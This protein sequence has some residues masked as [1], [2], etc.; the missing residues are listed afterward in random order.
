[1]RAAYGT[2]LSSLVMIKAHDMVADQAAAEFNVTWSR[3]TPIVVSVYD[4]AYSTILT[5]ECDHRFGM[6]VIGDPADVWAFRYACSSAINPIEHQVMETLFPGG[7]GRSITIGLAQMILNGEMVDVFISNG[8][9]V[10]MS[11]IEDLYLVLDLETGIVRDVMIT[12]MPM[13]GAY[14]FSDLQTEWASELCEDL[15]NNQSGLFDSIGDLSVYLG[16][17]VGTTVTATLEGLSLTGMSM[18]GIASAF[19]LGPFVFLEAMNPHM[20]EQ[21]EREGNF[22]TATWY[23]QNFLDRWKDALYFTIFQSGEWSNVLNEQNA[24]IDMINK[25]LYE[26][27]DKEWQEFYDSLGGIFDLYSY[28]DYKDDVNDSN[29]TDEEKQKALQIGL[30]FVLRLASGGSDDDNTKYI[31]LGTAIGTGVK[32]VSE[33]I[34]KGDVYQIVSG[35][36]LVLTGLTIAGASL[37]DGISEPLKV[38]IKVIT[39]DNN[40]ASGG[41]GGGVF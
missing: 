40:S 11:S 9:Q 19:I 22:N 20:I 35:G 23:K 32:L 36:I 13:S 26:Q 24:Y 31:P 12:Y 17:I 33:G 37:I 4:D 28:E 21:A 15:L 38:I 30:D 29:M 8:Y 6:D 18:F 5:L 10:M 25:P 41:G 16:A 1:M 27:R 7:G 34:S 2:F 14:C 39:T 3:T